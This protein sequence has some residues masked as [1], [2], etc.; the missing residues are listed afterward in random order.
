MKVSG[1]GGQEGKEVGSSLNWLLLM[2][3]TSWC[4]YN[5]SSQRVTSFYSLE[6]YH[7]LSQIRWQ[8]P[9]QVC[10][11]VEETLQGEVQSVKM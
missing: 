7:L 9:G 4:V 2:S 11:H 10:Q 3:V 5:P 1:Y 6:L 8:K